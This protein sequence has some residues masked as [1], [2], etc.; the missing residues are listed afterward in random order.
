MPA[1]TGASLA[2]RALER[3][4]PEH[5]IDGLVL[6]VMHGCPPGG[7]VEAVLSNDLM[8]AMSRADEHSRAGL[9]ALCMCLY[10]DVPAGC[11]GSAAK[12]AGWIEHGGLL[13]SREPRGE[14]NCEDW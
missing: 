11:H 10:N 1:L 8:G 2:A 12:V 13:V 6:Y 9:F 3:G 5:L 4:V 14:V 7:F